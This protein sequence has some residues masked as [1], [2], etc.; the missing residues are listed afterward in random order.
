MSLRFLVPVIFS[1]FALLSFLLASLLS[2]HYAESSWAMR[3]WGLA[4]WVISFGLAYGIMRMMMRP[5]EEFAARVEE[6][7]TV[8]PRETDGTDEAGPRSPQPRNEIERFTQVLTGVTDVLSRVESKAHF[9][10][11]VGES[12][13]MR[14][15]FSQILVVAKS[16]T[17]A[18]ILGESGTGKELVAEAIHAHSPRRSGPLVKVNCAAIP[19]SLVE[20]ELFGHE[21]GAFTGAVSVKKGRFEQASGGTIFLDEIGDMPLSAQAKLLRVLQ[22]REVV[23]VGG[24][25]SIVVDVRVIAATNKDLPL[26][27]REKRFREDLY[28]RINVFPVELPPLRDRVEDIPLFVEWFAGRSGKKCVLTDPARQLLM[29]YTWPGN[30]RELLH[31]LERAMLLADGEPVMPAHLPPQV[32]NNIMAVGSDDEDI[33]LNERLKRIERKLIEDA[34]QQAQ[35]VQVRAAER[36]GIPVRSLWH[37]VKKLEIDVGRFKV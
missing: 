4:V 11:M 5:M 18:L 25:K 19:D 16:E 17:N 7:G 26:E 32:G 36:L 35:G 29:A 22:D 10:D 15:V 9:P 34:L 23:R 27:V 6:L 24:S 21:K 30:I 12:G 14:A 1:G 13:V 31:C 33:N 2:V 8:V 28:F 3:F 20:S 37:R